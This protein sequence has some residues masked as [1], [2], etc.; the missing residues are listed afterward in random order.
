MG[1]CLGRD[2][3]KD[4]NPANGISNHETSPHQEENNGG[5]TSRTFRS[6]SASVVPAETSISTSLVGSGGGENRQICDMLFPEH[7]QV[8]KEV[9]TRDNIDKLVLKTLKVIRTLVEK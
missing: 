6:G 5:F 1:A 3:I 8:T 2:Q 4:V 7:V 9:I